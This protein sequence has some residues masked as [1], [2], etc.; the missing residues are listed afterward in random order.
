MSKSPR[1]RDWSEWKNHIA[2]ED[3]LEKTVYHRP[4]LK[5][6]TYDYESTRT[7]VMIPNELHEEV[8]SKKI[9]IWIIVFCA[10]ML[11]KKCHHS[12]FP[13]LRTSEEIRQS[14]SR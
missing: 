7:A 3:R 6:R 2:G 1:E 10:C 4:N 11:A 14:H 9:P 5:R 12:I 13:D 8:K